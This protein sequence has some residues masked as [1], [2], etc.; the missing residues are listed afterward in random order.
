MTLRE[1]VERA[2]YDKRV[3]ARDRLALG[4]ELLSAVAD[5]LTALRQE[6]KETK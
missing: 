3:P 2:L 4:Q 1:Q 6:L 5:A